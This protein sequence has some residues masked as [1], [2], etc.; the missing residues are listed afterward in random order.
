[1]EQTY[2]A[3]NINH[4]LTRDQVKT[5]LTQRK[6]R[7]KEIAKP[8]QENQRLSDRVDFTHKTRHNT[9]LH[10]NGLGKTLSNQLKND[11]NENIRTDTE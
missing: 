6:S 10:M 4:R 9:K 1:M 11:T 8:K 2:N 3:Y 7:T 5:T